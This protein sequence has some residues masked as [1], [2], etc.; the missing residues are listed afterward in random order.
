MEVLCKSQ[1]LKMAWLARVLS[2]SGF[3][4]LLEGAPA[5]A[6]SLW[7]GYLVG[8]LDRFNDAKKREVMERVKHAHVWYNHHI[9]F[10]NL[11]W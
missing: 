2:L 1:K 7:I 11:N 6:L 9:L 10:L 4:G 3:G 5:R 8:T